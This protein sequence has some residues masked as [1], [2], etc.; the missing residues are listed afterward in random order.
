MARIR[1]IKPEFFK[2]E[3][4]FQAELDFGAPLR[5]AFAGLWCA[6]DREG[7]FKW[8]PRQLK[9]DILPYDEVDFSRV[10]DALTTRGFIK[11][12]T[13]GTDSY[14][15]II[16]F[17][18]HQ[19][20]NN[21]ESDSELPNP[22]ECIDETLIESEFETRHPRVIHASSTPLV[23]DQGEGK[24]RE[25]KGKEGNDHASSTPGY[26][27]EFLDFFDDWF[28]EA[29]KGSKPQTF[30]FWRKLTNKNPGLKT[31]LIVQRDRQ[32][33]EREIYR[34]YRV[35]LANPQQPL[36]WLRASGWTYDV[37]DDAEIQVISKAQNPNHQRKPAHLSHVDIVQSAAQ[38]AQE[39]AKEYGVEHAQN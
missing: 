7:R 9:L 26:P 29:S 10:L 34:K 21:R 32:K 23:Q 12:Y 28:L 22:D 24:G 2:H 4:L 14:G 38:A 20:I 6:A 18:K 36:V 17:T 25:R 8:R 35:W 16:N 13:S 5:I 27:Q 19:V 30:E 39:L 3:E 15:V 1:T 33:S 11:K 37:K 31:E